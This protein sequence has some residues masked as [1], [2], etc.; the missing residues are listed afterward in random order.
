MA[1]IQTQKQEEAENVLL[2]SL[3]V[4]NI[5]KEPRYLF[6]SI[7]LFPYIV[8]QDGNY[9]VM[10]N[11]SEIAYVEVSDESPYV[12]F[13]LKNGKSIEVGWGDQ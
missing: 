6:E 4:Q 9:Q 8:V 10:V 5:R 3:D 1:K 13:T 7:A 2:I 12:I 11:T